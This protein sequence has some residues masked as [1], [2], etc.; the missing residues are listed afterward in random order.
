MSQYSMSVDREIG[1]A[2]TITAGK[3]KGY[4]KTN[5]LSSGNRRTL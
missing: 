4:Y 2:L 3:L 1:A 5:F